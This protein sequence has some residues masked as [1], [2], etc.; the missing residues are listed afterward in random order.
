M[1]NPPTWC[2]ES[3]TKGLDGDVDDAF[4]IDF[5]VYN[6][7][8]V[9]TIVLSFGATTSSSRAIIIPSSSFVFVASSF[10]DQ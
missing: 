6:A 10:M 5:V 1:S 9:A 4:V 3:I 2:L 7:H 8:D